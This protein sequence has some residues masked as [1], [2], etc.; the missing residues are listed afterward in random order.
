MTIHTPSHRRRMGV[1]AASLVLALGL[2]A[3]GDN[4]DDDTPDTDAGT[5][6]GSDS[7]ENAGDDAPQEEVTIR[8]AWWGSD[9]RH[10]VTNEVIEAFEAEYPHITVEADFTSW[11]NYFER[12]NVAAAGNDLPDVITQEERFLTEYA[13]RGLLA[14]LGELGLDTSAVDESVL[15]AGMIDGALYGVATGIN[16]HAIIADPAIFAEAGVELPDDTTWTW[17][18]YEEIATAIAE[19]TDGEYYGV[20]NYSFIEPVLKIIARQKGEEVFTAD[21]E[22]GVSAETVEEFFQRAVDLGES[23]AQPNASVSTEVQGAGVEGSLPATNS[24]AMAWF[25]SNQLP[26]VQSASGR[27]LVL[28]R[29]PG[30]SQFE[31]SGQ[32]FKPSMY[33]SVSERTE[34]PEA[35]Q[36]LVDFLINSEAAGERILSDRGLPANTDVRAAV[37]PLLSDADNLAAEFVEGLEGLVVD[38][39]PVPPVGAG[40]VPA[41]TTRINSDVLF[42]T[43]TPAEAAER[44]L[45]E[46]NSAIS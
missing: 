18:D 24:G 26:A 21:G 41:I 25:W 2:A 30:E 35:A 22:V 3:C 1:V 32:F 7:T 31:R 14:D 19:N 8:F 40:E 12:L 42:G 45:S 6:S 13:S 9:T 5:D 10:A 17:E 11:D 4:G 16:V 29:A 46:V 27:D 34:H 43:I 33:Y 23:G 44:W 37:L 36:L 15:Q 38:G 28:L 39:T 20:Q